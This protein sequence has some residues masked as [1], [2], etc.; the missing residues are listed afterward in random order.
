MEMCEK[1][2]LVKE[3]RVSYWEKHKKVPSDKD[4]YE[5]FESGGNR[6]EKP[7][8]IYEKRD[9]YNAADWSHNIDY[10]N[11]D[12]EI[13]KAWHRYIKEKE[14]LSR[15][16]HNKQKHNLIKIPLSA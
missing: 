16:W 13:L 3:Y 7:T 15:H 12:Y 8:T 14:R 9:K 1:N 2:Y 10:D 11:I 6:M 4:I 5:F